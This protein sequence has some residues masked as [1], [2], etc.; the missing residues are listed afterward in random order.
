MGPRFADA[1]QLAS[2]LHRTQ[3]RKSTQIPYIGHLLIVAGLV[4]EAGGDEDTVIGALLHDAVED[5]GGAPT[6]AL[7]GQKF[8]DRVAAIVDACSDT[9]EDPKPPW[10]GRKEKYIA[11]IP[12]KTREAR[13]VSLADKV[14]NA[15]AILRDHQ[16]MG[17]EV[18]QRFSG[19]K[20]GTLWYYRALS[21][22]FRPDG[23]VALCRALDAAVSELERSSSAD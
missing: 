5:C 7:I 11:G 16:L 9:D 3:T 23:D 12:H 20:D 17:D 21:D 6:L 19:R 8:G 1:L 18:W 14:H 15:Q 10:R 4:I 13:L 2:E 22:A